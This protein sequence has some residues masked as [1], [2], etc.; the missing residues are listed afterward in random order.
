MNSLPT[1]AIVVLH[2]Q[3]F[4]TTRQCLE[5]LFRLRAHTARTA[6]VQIL[7][8]DNGS[9]DGSGIQ[10]KRWIVQRKEAQVYFL[11]SPENLG[12]AGGNNLAIR[13]ALEHLAPRYLWLLNNDTVPRP[14]A[15]VQLLRCA[16][17]HP[18]AAL[19]GST[20]LDS[21]TGR[22]QAA[23]GCR[24]YPWISGY[25]SCL[26]GKTKEEAWNK[27]VRLDYI[28]GASLFV[29]AD[30]FQ[31]A[32]LLS[33]DYFLYFEELDMVRRLPPGKG[34]YW[35]RSAVVVHQGG[36]SLRSRSGEMLSVYHATLSSLRYTWRWHPHYLP[37]VIAAR[38]LVKSFWFACTGRWHLFSPL[39][40]GV[41]DFFFEK[42]S[43]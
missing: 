27:R 23:G 24:Y 34:L 21:A 17:A 18:S 1:V 25:R 22:V 11:S 39:Y 6:S 8:V 33:E 38:L 29:R 9:V 3:G 12:F 5:A 10:L 26:A 2:W 43:V 19:I 35:C 16:E 32:G 42:R 13:F 7:L 36:G 31:V 14:D 28:A 41:R 37:T 40:R 20:I 15:L 30:Y 4:A